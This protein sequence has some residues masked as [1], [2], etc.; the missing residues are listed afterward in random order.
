M[1]TH[2][3]IEKLFDVF[4][5]DIT[6]NDTGI[7]IL[8]GPNGYGKTTILKILDALSVDNYRFFKSLLFKEITLQFSDG[9]TFRLEKNN[10]ELIAKPNLSPNSRRKYPNLLPLYF[11]REQRLLRPAINNGILGAAAAAA[12]L[13]AP[14]SFRNTIEDYAKELR[15]SIKDTLAMSSKEN[16]KLDSSFPARLFDQEDGISEAAFKLR[17]DQVKSI[18]N[19]LNKFGLYEVREDTHSSY[20]SENA[21]ALSVYIADAEEKL[22]VFAELL[23]KLKVFTTILN[24][25]RFSFKRIIISREEG[26]TF[27]TTQDKPLALN[28]LSSGEQQEVVLLYELLFKVKPG[29][30]VLIDEPEL[31]LHVVW[32]MQFLDDLLDIIKLQKINVIVATHSPQIINNHWDLTVDLEENFRCSKI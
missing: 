14:D 32:Q 22:A 7:T 26:F 20:K 13:S 16:Q 30:L 2:I 28:D 9:D 23:R 18:Q 12:A 6:F 8:T 21:K 1:L 25:R 3:K 10:N 17:F 4:D 24:E 31:S 29:T 19:E 5:Y 27:K 11:I 15:E